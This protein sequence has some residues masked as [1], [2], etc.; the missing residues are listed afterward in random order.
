MRDSLRATR[1]SRPGKQCE[2]W[3]SKRVPLPPS[4]FPPRSIWPDRGRVVQQEISWATQRV[5][6]ISRLCNRRSGREV[7]VVIARGAAAA[8]R[9]AA[10]WR[11]TSAAVVALAVRAMKDVLRT[12]LAICT[13][14]GAVIDVTHWVAITIA[15]PVGRAARRAVV[16]A[17]RIAWA[18]RLAAIAIEHA[19]V[20]ARAA[21][22]QI[23]ATITRVAAFRQPQRPRCAPRHRN[24]AWLATRAARITTGLTTFWTNCSATNGR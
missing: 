4:A 6:R 19:A 11:W 9:A 20:A 7:V 15:A 23:A 2:G 12:A 18:T 24:M 1:S 3:K 17:T 22:F 13:N 21:S 8:E 5:V 14:A 16:G 10:P